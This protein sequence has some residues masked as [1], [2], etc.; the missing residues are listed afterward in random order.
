MEAEGLV[1]AGGKSLRMGGRHK[2][3]L[4]YQ[5]ESFTQILIKELKKETPWVRVSYGRERKEDCGEYPAVMDIYPD[6][7]PIGGLHA[8][9]RGCR[10]EVVLTAACDMP[11]MKIELLRFLLKSMR[12]NETAGALYDGAVPVTEGRIHPLAAVYRKS[13][14]DTFEEQIKKENYR[15]Q[16]ALR[17]LRILYVDVTGNKI[18]EQMLRNINTREEYERLMGI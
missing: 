14:A 4:L 15:L 12:R 13:A 17:H 7:G 11:L 8:G 10:G 16:V 6:C 2:G 18:F 1:L 3:G 9:L 5:N